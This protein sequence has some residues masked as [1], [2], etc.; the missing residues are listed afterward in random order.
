MLW[1]H[2]KVRIETIHRLFVFFQFIFVIFS[3]T[4]FE[5]LKTWLLVI[6]NTWTWFLCVFSFFHTCLMQYVRCSDKTISSFENYSWSQKTRK[7]NN[8][9]IINPLFNGLL[10][11][12]SRHF[13]HSMYF[14]SLLWGL[15]KYY[16]TQK[17]ILA[18]HVLKTN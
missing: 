8:S 12:I 13:A 10:Y 6:K 16:A 5:T 1:N 17:K 7:W 3:M 11:V 2:A 18:Y 4:N 15:E 9:G 14:S